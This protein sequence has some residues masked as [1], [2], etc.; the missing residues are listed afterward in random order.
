MIS[1]CIIAVLPKIADNQTCVIFNYLPPI[2][3][4]NEIKCSSFLFTDFYDDFIATLSLQLAGWIA[5]LAAT[6]I[7]IIYAC[8]C[9]ADLK[10]IGY[11]AIILSLLGGKFVYIMFVM[12]K[13]LYS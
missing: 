13:I 8:A 3:C 5:I 1:L 6:I 9:C 12:P 7:M 10:V 4:K 11:I 2:R